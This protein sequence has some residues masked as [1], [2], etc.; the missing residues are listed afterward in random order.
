MAV[1][2]N[3]VPAGEA[4]VVTVRFVELWARA[5][6]TERTIRAKTAKILYFKLS[7]PDEFRFSNVDPA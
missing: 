2:L 6:A 7:S 1:K 4:G 3:D 5:M